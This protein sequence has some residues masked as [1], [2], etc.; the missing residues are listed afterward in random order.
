M[1][2]ILNLS[3][4]PLIDLAARKITRYDWVVQA[5]VV[6]IVVLAVLGLGFAAYC[7]Y[8]GGSLYYVVKLSAFYFKIACVFK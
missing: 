6:S 2:E 4:L 1:S 8:K 7:V 3:S 5:F